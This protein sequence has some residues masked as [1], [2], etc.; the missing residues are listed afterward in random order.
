MPKGIPKYYWDANLFIAWLK[1]EVRKTGEMAG[2]AEIVWMV[3]HHQA[4]IVTSVITKGEVLEC[5]LAPH[6]ESVFTNIFKR[7]SIVAI[8]FNDPIADLCRNIKNRYVAQGM[9]MKLGECPTFGDCYRSTR[10]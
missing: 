10:R 2:L 4:I 8:D 9:K 1:N 5:H 7:P 3:D 6:A